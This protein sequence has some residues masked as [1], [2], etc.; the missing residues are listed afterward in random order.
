MNGGVISGDEA[1]LA[2]ASKS[3]EDAA[4]VVDNDAFPPQ[5]S[6]PVYESL[7]IAMIAGVRAYGVRGIWP[8]G[9][10]SPGATDE[11][12]SDKDTRS[13]T[14]EEH[15]VATERK[16]LWVRQIVGYPVERNRTK[17]WSKEFVSFKLGEPD[18]DAYEPPSQFP[19]VTKWMYPLPC[20]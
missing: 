2:A 10:I 7:G 6:G 11:D 5:A 1:T 18:L 3:D 13:W 4:P 9:P 8:I 20:G 14:A 16:E 19:V 17:Q 15:W 12:K